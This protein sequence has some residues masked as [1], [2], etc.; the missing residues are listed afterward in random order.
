MSTE[1][2]RAVIIKDDGV[3]L[4]SKA[5]N[6]DH[7]FQVWRCDGLSRALRDGGQRRL[8]EEL[9]KMFRSY[10]QI[11]GTHRSLD[12]YIY[13]TRSAKAQQLISQR[14][15]ELQR[16]FAALSDTDKQS[17]SAAADRP[18]LTVAAT[19]YR[20]AERNTEHD[21]CAALADL[22]QEGR[23]PKSIP[24]LVV[25][26]KR[27]SLQELGVLLG[28]PV[29]PADV[30]FCVDILEGTLRATRSDLG[31]PGMSVD[32]QIGDDKHAIVLLEGQCG[33]PKGYVYG[34]QEDYIARFPINHSTPGDCE[35]INDTIEVGGGGPD[36]TLTVKVSDESCRF[37]KIVEGGATA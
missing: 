36:S 10:C 27:L 25:N 19:A 1:L 30:A 21:L 35:K 11:E 31:F 13:A 22:A 8:D 5:G 4:D 7:P 23:N 14:D 6:D 32:L 17:L 34:K 24:Y 15:R 2:I 28:K 20:K 12:P 29:A 16:A 9:I 33:G 37:T 18:E 26:G 3:Y